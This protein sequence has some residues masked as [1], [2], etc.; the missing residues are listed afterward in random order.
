MKS[1]KT[2]FF[3]LV[4]PPILVLILFLAE[5]TAALSRVTAQLSAIDD[6]V[7][8][9]VSAAGLSTAVH[10]EIQEYIQVLL[11]GRRAD[12]AAQR[13]RT[14]AAW[15]KL[16]GHRYRD[17]STRDA[18]RQDFKLILED[19][20]QAAALEESGFAGSGGARGLTAAGKTAV[21]ELESRLSL[22]ADRFYKRKYA[23]ALESAYSLSGAL[24][25]V[26][27][28]PQRTLQEEVQRLIFNLRQATDTADLHV[29]TV[30]ANTAVLKW[31]ALGSDGRGEATAARIKVAERLESLKERIEE[32][33]DS[34]ASAPPLEFLKKITAATEDLKRAFDGVLRFDRRTQ[35]AR[36]TAALNDEIELLLETRFERAV[37][38]ALAGQNR[39]IAANLG[40]IARS[41]AAIY[42]FT[43]ILSMLAVLLGG[44]SLFILFRKVIV[45]VL[46]LKTSVEKVENRFSDI[47]VKA[48]WIGEI[49][50]MAR[51]FNGMM[52]R[53]RTAQED[54]V[55][56]QRRLGQSEKMASIGQLAAGVAH[57]I[58]NPL[59]VILGFSQSLA[60]KME[61]G[62]FL[63]LPVNSIVREALRCKDLVQN[64]L[65]FSRATRADR[66]PLD[67]NAAV[68]GAIELFRTQLNGGS[69]KI[70]ESL[71]P[72]LPPV[73]AN[74]TQIQ[75]VVINLATNAADAM[76][77]KGVI[78]IATE[79]VAGT[80]YSW[81]RLR[82]SDTG[83]GIP[84]E[85]LPRVFE[86]FFTTKPVGK[87]TGLGLS[88]VHEIVQK[89]S[90]TITVASRPGCTEFTVMLPIRTGHE[91]ERVKAAV[92][93]EKPFFGFKGEA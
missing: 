72:G 9:T 40:N 79:L 51:A 39:E 1:L 11:S 20:R 10:R 52:K 14:Q 84:P 8:Q 83:S 46:D 7:V 48:D 29:F 34:A 58:N 44:G 61:P 45:P 49:G 88:L 57:E 91:L 80:P 22:H 18:D 33:P 63:E 62:S 4:I 17:A 69:V 19:L 73:L 67:I 15:E 75:Q 27:F 85:T 25:Q 5:S 82:L 13:E 60:S 90:G 21:T 68:E 78:K 92:V 59:G 30:R 76:D 81:M 38:D 50:E 74:K 3:I 47:E 2:L 28:V 86:P 42:V 66:E 24:N 35:S 71:S 36:I 12:L 53:L 55:A 54:T 31:L 32:G 26:A 43:V 56:A 6:H 41:V 70:E 87:G 37:A 16:I 65:T 23:K 89:H 64:L 77:G 93:V